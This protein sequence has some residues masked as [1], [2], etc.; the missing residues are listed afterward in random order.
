MLRSV[1]SSDSQAAAAAAPASLSLHSHSPQEPQQT[2]KKQQLS[3]NIE[4]H[5][6]SYL[7]LAGST[8]REGLPCRAEPASQGGGYP[9]LL[10]LPPFHFYET[11]SSFAP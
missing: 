11:F 9:L 8:F 6:L 7:G 5:Y 1:S 2:F 10:Y 3:P 4:F